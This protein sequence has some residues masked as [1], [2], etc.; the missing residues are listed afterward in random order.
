MFTYLFFSAM[1]AKVSDSS[2]FS[3]YLQSPVP[4]QNSQAGSV[5]FVEAVP[6]MYE[7]ETAQ[8]VVAGGRFA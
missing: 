2:S 5:G 4:V 8:A 1:G 3:A 6:K 7:L